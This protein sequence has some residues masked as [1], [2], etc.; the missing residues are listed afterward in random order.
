MVPRR[1]DRQL[2]IIVIAAPS[3]NY[4]IVSVRVG[5][6]GFRW[7]RVAGFYYHARKWQRHSGLFVLYPSSKLDH[8]WSGRRFSTPEH[9]WGNCGPLA[10]EKR[11]GLRP[12]SI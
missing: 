9:P 2:G 5:V 7:C 11:P 3:Q 12:F 8:L 10:Q 1:T 4:E 6:T